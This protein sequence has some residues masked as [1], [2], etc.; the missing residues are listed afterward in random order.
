MKKEYDGVIAEMIFHNSENGYTVAVFEINGEEAEEDYFTVV[1]TMPGA[2]AGKTYHISG[3]FVENPRYGE[4]FAVSGAMETMPST[5]EGIKGFL[6]S[7]AIK[8]VGRKTAAAIVAA[9][10]EDTFD[11]IENHPEKLTEVSG[12]GPKVAAKIEEAFLQHR[13]F[14]RISLSLQQYGITPA[15]TLKLYSVYGGETVEAVMENPYRLTDEVF[16]IGFKKADAIAGKI[17]IAPDDEFRVKSGI[18]FTLSWFAGEG[19]TYLPEEVLLEKAGQLLGQPR[20]LIG[21]I[22][23][24][25]AFFGDVHIDSIENSR[26]VYLTAFYRAEQNVCSCLRQISHGRLKPV[27]GDADTLIARTEEA[28]GISLSG[29]QKA[30]VKS[31]LDEGVSV[32]TG[33]P[34]TGKTTIIN[35]IINIFEDSGLKVAI[36]APTG[37]AAKRI[38]ET[39][40]HDASTIHRLL[41]YSFIEDDDYMSFGRNQDNPLEYDA[42]IV[43]EA[44][45][46]D[47]MLMNGL[48]S[49]ILPGARFVIVGDEDQLP[50]VGAGNV[51]RDIIASEYISCSRLTEIYRQARESMIVVN[52]HRINHGEY[53][54]CNGKDKDFFLLQRKTEKEMLATIK[55]LCIRRLPEYYRDIVEGGLDAIRD[56]QVLTPVRKGT[57]GCL[58]MNRELQEVLNP[59]D[60]VKNE[61]THGERIFREGDKVMQIKNNYELQ[62]KNREDFTEGEGVF[63][64][65]VGFIQVI[66]RDYSEMTVVFD[67]VKYV[68]YSF[69]QLDELELAYAVTVHKSQGS[70]FPIVVMPVSWFP[71]VLATR[72]LLY[73]GVTRGKQAVVLVGSPDKLNGMVDNNRISARFSGLA[74]RLKRLMQL[75]GE[76]M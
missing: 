15:Q 8:G 2:A 29:Q 38:T 44:S 43:D 49:A 58:N 45:M 60:G 50:S 52:A 73:T 36:A 25:M 63:N 67:E 7:G 3:E 71:P 30:A 19:N 27:K 39:S 40:G 46:I 76:S 57:L 37:R 33:G 24:Q 48:V 12:I 6:A 26:V 16:G 14:A 21:D 61:K 13:E 70:E 17:G 69:N 56:I 64:G 47:L 74:S 20:E 23:E 55:D 54:D 35:A 9:F 68:T 65:D 75:E 72:N 32:I 31:C 1:G 53:P 51:L 18:R 11:V 28:S 66:D 22:L 59:P 4:Q 42:V 10:G 41:E 62:W 5:E 34:G